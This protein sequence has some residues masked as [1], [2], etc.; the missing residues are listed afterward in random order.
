MVVGILLFIAK[1]VVLFP[2]VWKAY[3]P[4]SPDGIETMTGAFG[5]A[6]E[7]IAP[8]GYVRVR[9]ELWK[10]RTTDSRNIIEKGVRVRVIGGEGLTLSVEADPQKDESFR[11]RF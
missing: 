11:P 10:A 9:G 4:G 1:D 6:E 8:E 3:D 7:R 2:F 5:V